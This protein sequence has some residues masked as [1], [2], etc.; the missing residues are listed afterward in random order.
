[1]K[2]IDEHRHDLVPGVVGREFGVETPDPE[3]GS[4]HDG[5]SSGELVAEG[6]SFVVVLATAQTVVE[7][8]EE[9]VVEVA[10]RGGVSIAVGSPGGSPGP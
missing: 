4:S 3:S 1:V 10:E 9:P 5:C 8:S 6:P 2:F 7:L